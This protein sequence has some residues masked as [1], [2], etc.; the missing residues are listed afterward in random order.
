MAGQM[1][2]KKDRAL[3]RIAE[4]YLSFIEFIDERIDAKKVVLERGIQKA[5]DLAEEIKTTQG[6]QIREQRQL[7]F[8]I[9]ADINDMLNEEIKRLEA[10][11]YESEERKIIRKVAA[12]AKK[13]QKEIAENKRLIES[14][15][16]GEGKRTKRGIRVPAKEEDE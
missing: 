3:T 11:N 2:V 10:G 14:M 5:N 4:E 16:S 9:Q 13:I 12:E 15:E 1:Y 7:E 8:N 6:G